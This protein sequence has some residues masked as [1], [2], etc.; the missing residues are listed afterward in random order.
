MTSLLEDPT[1]IILV[2][3]IVEAVLGVILLRTG[4]GVLLWAMGGVMALVVIGVL[5]EWLV[6]TERER[7]EETIENAAAA[8]EANDFEKFDTYLTR[9]AEKARGLARWAFSRAE[10]SRVKITKLDIHIVRQTSPP[11]A[12]AELS[13]IVTF[14]DRMGESPYNNYP[15]NGTLTLRLE[16][17]RWLISGYTLKNDPRR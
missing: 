1:P 5:V 4:R 14:K 2:G 10:F 6:V 3:I 7:V 16:N 9:D 13:G 12:K 11:T 15:P 8:V 17:G